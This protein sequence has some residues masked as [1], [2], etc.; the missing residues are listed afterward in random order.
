VGGEVGPGL[1]RDVPPPEDF[2]GQRDT[3]PQAALIDR[4]T[5]DAVLDALGPSTPTLLHTMPA[6]G[7]AH[8]EP[9]LRSLAELLADP[10]SL[11]PPEAVVP[12]L[13]YRGRVSL[14][15]GREKLG[16]KS[17]L[18]TAGAAAVTRGA[19][20]LREPS[21]LGPILW[22]TADQEHAAEITQRAMRF[23]ADP[24][25]F[26][27]LW[28]HDPVADLQVALERVQPVLLVIDTL[29]NFAR[30]VVSDPHSSAEWPA[31]LLPLVTLARE[32]GIAVL[33]S[34]HAKKADGGG[35]RDSTAIGA[36]VDM[37][38][39][40]TPDTG[41][42]ARR[43]VAALGRWPAANFAVALVG[44][45]YELMAGS[46]LSLDARVLLFIERHPRCGKREVR[47][48]VGGRVEDVDSAV[49]RLL[50][51][52]AITKAGTAAKHAYVARDAAVARTPD[53][54]A[55]QEGSDDL[56]F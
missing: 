43:N 32:Q 56:P 38:L 51:R 41:D 6:P 28:P 12:R 2:N 50:E 46:E 24:E 23:G 7:A 13:A 14:V 39:E 22:V 36:I 21:A 34:H 42:P 5:E 16:G 31:V 44:D 40:L 48:G 45:R 3:E 37:L 53:G 33:I 25:R 27:V 17:T 35:Y 55:S 18:L 26:H 1:Q 4:M 29:A 11:K 49:R 9:M 30:T 15:V 54:R 10:D 20:F 19:H 47:D 52:E 8:P